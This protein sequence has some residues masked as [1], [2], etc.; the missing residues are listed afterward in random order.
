[1]SALGPYALALLAGMLAFTSPCCLPLMPGY[2]SYVSGVGGEAAGAVAV[3]S[4][5]VVSAMLFVS[6]FASVFTLLGAGASEAGAL[7]LRNRLI[8][9]RIAGVF[10]IAMG[11]AAMGLVRLPFLYRERR[12]DLRRI[13]SG[14]AGAVP[15]GMAFAIGWTPCIGPV[16]AGILTAAASAQSATRGALLLFTFSLGMGIPFVLLALGYARSV[17]AFA[18]VRRHGLA[19]ERAGGVVLVTIGVL[20][21]TGS[22]IRMFSPLVRLFADLGWPPL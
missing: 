5:V 14:P 12:F 6:G 2:V 18:W 1:V 8:L 7:L 4:R 13:R 16:L 19:I 11:L 10:V 17:R 22:W 15:L 3:R 9:T 20:M 21:V